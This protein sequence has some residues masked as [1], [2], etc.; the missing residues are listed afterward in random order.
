MSKKCNPFLFRFHDW[1]E[2]DRCDSLAWSIIKGNKF[3]QPIIMIKEK[4][5]S[6][7]KIRTW[8]K[9][10]TGEIHH[11]DKDFFGK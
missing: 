7:D 8:Y 5:S 2:I 6:C 11:F 1:N 4:C 10:Q 9:D 3:S